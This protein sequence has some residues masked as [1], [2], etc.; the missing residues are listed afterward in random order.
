VFVALSFG[1]FG[2]CSEPPPPVAS[3]VGREEVKILSNTVPDS[4]SIN[5]PGTVTRVVTE[6]PAITVALVKTCTGTD[7]RT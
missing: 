5:V 7:S 4:D 3:G 6:V 1:S 2:F